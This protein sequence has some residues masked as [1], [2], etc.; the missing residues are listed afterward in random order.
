LLLWP[1]F[2]SQRIPLVRHKFGV[3]LPPT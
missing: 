1:V 3:H 2:R